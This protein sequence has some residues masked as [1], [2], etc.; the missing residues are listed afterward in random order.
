VPGEWLPTFQQGQYSPDTTKRSAPFWDQ[1]YRAI[2]VADTCCLL[3]Q[4]HIITLR[5]LIA[6]AALDQ[7]FSLVFVVRLEVGIRALPN[8]HLF[9][10][11]PPA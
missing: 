3:T 5:R 7:T 4:F 6:V 8:N 11:Q 2:V 10:L 9:I 1:G